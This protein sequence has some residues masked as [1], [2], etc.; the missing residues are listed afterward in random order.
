[1]ASNGEA[2]TSAT[3]ER[4][5]TT[6]ITTTDSL[7]RKKIRIS[8]LALNLCGDLLSILYYKKFNLDM[9]IDIELPAFSDKSADYRTV[10]KGVS[11]EITMMLCDY[12]SFILN[13]SKKNYLNK[14][15][16]KI[17][18]IVDDSLSEFEK[19]EIMKDANIFNGNYDE[20]FRIKTGRKKEKENDNLTYEQME[21]LII[22]K[23]TLYNKTKLQKSLLTQFLA[24][25]LVKLLENYKHY[26]ELLF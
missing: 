22:Q 16:D 1:M 2:T 13:V 15:Q 4:P 26:M 24:L 6:T 23:E 12:L 11:E 3:D 10:K 18:N 8:D 19:S 25:L 21:K 14:Y 5:T 17:F 9:N 20:D 7:L